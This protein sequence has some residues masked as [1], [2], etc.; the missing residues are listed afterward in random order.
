M[1]RRLQ[2]S[3]KKS[4]DHSVLATALAADVGTTHAA[5]PAWISA[6]AGCAVCYSAEKWLTGPSWK[7]A[8][9]PC[10]GRGPALLDERVHKVGAGM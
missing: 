6:Q 2:D 7:E 4:S 1:H 8:A 3:T 9:A 5:D 10:K